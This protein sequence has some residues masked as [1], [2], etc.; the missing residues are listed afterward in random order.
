MIDAY[1]LNSV[2]DECG[3]RRA[4]KI[5]YVVLDKDS[6][7]VLKFSETVAVNRGFIGR[8]FQDEV[9]AFNWLVSEN[10]TV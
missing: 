3:V 8:V 2:L 5:A 1:Q 7:E 4:W 10:S 9:K 6:Y